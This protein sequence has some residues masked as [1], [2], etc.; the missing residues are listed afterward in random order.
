MVKENGGAVSGNQSL[1]SVFGRRKIVRTTHTN[2]VELLRAL[3][4]ELI[5]HLTTSGI[6]VGHMKITGV[7]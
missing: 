4:D 3:M 1:S 2:T 6:K 7:A 5:E